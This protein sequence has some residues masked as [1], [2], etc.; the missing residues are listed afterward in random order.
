MSPSAGRKTVKKAAKRGATKKTSA[1][2]AASKRGAARKATKKSTKKSVIRKPAAKK[3]ATKKSAVRK[4]RAGKATSAARKSAAKPARTAA[5]TAAPPAGKTAAS[6]SNKPAAAS[7]PV[8]TRGQQKTPSS[9]RAVSPSVARK[10][11]EQLLKAKQERVRQGP[12][13]PA[14][15]PFTG[16]HDVDNGMQS[17]PNEDSAT[18]AA[19]APDPEATYGGT[20][21]NHGRGN[22]GMRNQK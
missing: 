22:Q 11:F 21:F 5:R 7:K 12:S 2:S 17:T 13:Y 4:A 10:H 3:S 1:K 20:E 14:P 9:P 19:G 8:S 6:R 18:P 16:R 15:N